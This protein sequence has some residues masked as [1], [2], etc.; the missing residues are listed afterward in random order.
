MP[1]TLKATCIIFIIEGGFQVAGAP[2]KGLLEGH[3][4]E[5]ELEIELLEDTKLVIIYK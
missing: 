2:Q 3:K 1:V 4:V 5:G